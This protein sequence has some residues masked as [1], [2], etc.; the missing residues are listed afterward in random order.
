MVGFSPALTGVWGINRNG[1]LPTA[2]LGLVSCLQWSADSKGFEAGPH[3][4]EGEFISCAVASVLD[5]R[6]ALTVGRPMFLNMSE[7]MR[8]KTSQALNTGP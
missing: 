2:C 1:M 7:H 3:V 4:H 8:H 5:R 6:T